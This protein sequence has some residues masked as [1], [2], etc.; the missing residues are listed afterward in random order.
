MYVYTYMHTIT[1]SEKRDQEIEGAGMGIW[2]V[3]EVRK[4]KKKCN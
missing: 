3:L 4:G 1:T 2:E